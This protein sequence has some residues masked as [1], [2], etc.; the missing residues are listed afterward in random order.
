MVSQWF[1]ECMSETAGQSQIYSQLQELWCSM[2]QRDAIW[3][4][5]WM[6]PTK[7]S[8]SLKWCQIK[9]VVTTGMGAK[10]KWSSSLC[11]HVY[12]THLY[13]YI[14]DQY[15]PVNFC[16][17]LLFLRLWIYFDIS[18]WST[19]SC[20]LSRPYGTQHALGGM[21]AP[22]FSGSIR[23]CSQYGILVSK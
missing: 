23:A 15:T 3:H 5:I 7:P 21:Q 17:L 20:M 13:S 1:C 4:G 22:L 19:E 12:C 8:I 14:F 2:T 9:M 6:S 11:S 10:G 16:I 18:T